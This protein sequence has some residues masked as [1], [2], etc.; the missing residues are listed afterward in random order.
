MKAFD[1]E[2]GGDDGVGADDGAGHGGRVDAKV[3]VGADKGAEV[4][5]VGIDNLVFD[6]GFDWFTVE[7]TVGGDKTGS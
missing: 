5:M 7:A 2:V 4:V 6:L 3:G 1:G